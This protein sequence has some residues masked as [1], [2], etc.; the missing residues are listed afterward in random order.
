M[1]EDNV[2]ILVAVI[3]SPNGH[4]NQG[5]YYKENGKWQ[6]IFHF[7]LTSHFCLDSMAKIKVRVQYSRTTC[8]HFDLSSYPYILQNSISRQRGFPLFQLFS[9]E[10]ST[11]S[12][13]LAQI[14]KVCKV[15]STCESTNTPDND[16]YWLVIRTNIWEI[17][18][19]Y[20][21]GVYI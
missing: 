10:C 16:K 3:L 5:H 17:K 12:F 4:K 8:I 20:P 19:K 2:Q 6:S 9:L 13:S 14:Q 11:L 18:I 1:I 21:S 7:Q 15:L